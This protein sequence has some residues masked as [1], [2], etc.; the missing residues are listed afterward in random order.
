MA[1]FGWKSFVGGFL[2][3]TA[4]LEL[5]W[6]EEAQ[7]VYTVI[8]TGVLLARDRVMEEVEKVNVLASDVLA[9][10]KVK[11]AAIQEKKRSAETETRGADE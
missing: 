2:L 7:K 8:T 10:A 5:L 6:T 4:G 1:K 11:A 9:D 3:G